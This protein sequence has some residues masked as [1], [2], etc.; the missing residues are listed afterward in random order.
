V[1]KLGIDIEICELTPW[2]DVLALM[3]HPIAHR[4]RVTLCLDAD[5]EADMNEAELEIAKSTPSFQSWT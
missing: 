4:I 3:R 5:I 1:H 2:H